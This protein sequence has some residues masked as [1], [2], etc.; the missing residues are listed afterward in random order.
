MDL[1][2][3]YSSSAYSCGE[4]Y[5]TTKKCDGYNEEEQ[6]KFAVFEALDRATTFEE[7]VTIIT[8]LEHVYLLFVY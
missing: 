6:K 8:P 3:N 1:N 5:E 4:F 2:I 7:I